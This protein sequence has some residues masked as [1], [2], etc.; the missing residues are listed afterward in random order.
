[1]ALAKQIIIFISGQHRLNQT[2]L[3]AYH[4]SL[5]KIIETRKVVMRL[6]KNFSFPKASTASP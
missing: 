2:I 4:G 3:Q 1:L 6:K 5:S